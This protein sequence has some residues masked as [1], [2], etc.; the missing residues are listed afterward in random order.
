MAA[1]AL[2]AGAQEDLA[3]QAFVMFAVAAVVE[4]TAVT[5]VAAPWEEDCQ[6]AAATEAAS[7]IDSASVQQAELMAA[8][9]A[10]AAAADVAEEP[11][12]VVAVHGLKVACSSSF[13][14]D[15]L[16]IRAPDRALTRPCYCWV[17]I[18]DAY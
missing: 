6:V 9:I 15:C 12:L 7:V 17:E 13:H 2:T 16:H 5:P 10:A 3:E 14:L 1:E 11:E 18:V 4:C 8:Y